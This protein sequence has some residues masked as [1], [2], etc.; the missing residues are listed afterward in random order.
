MT[1]TTAAREMHELQ[2]ALAKHLEDAKT[3]ERDLRSQI[4][5]RKRV[6][7][8]SADGID[9][10]KVTLARTIIY[11]RGQYAKG[12]EDRASVIR[13]AVKQLS[14]G[15][16]I[17]AFYGDLWHHYF[18]T[19]SYDRWYGQRSDHPYHM[20]PGH[21][22]IIFEVGLVDAVRKNRTYSD[23]TPDEIEAAIYFLTNLERVQAAEQK[24]REFATA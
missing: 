22:S 21:G 14:T 9:Y 18:A 12:G 6:L 5:A 13:D 7:E 23:L 3:R 1:L 19:K 24:A 2:V 15:E 8:C 20:G 4:E 10:D 17:R 16:P 11:V